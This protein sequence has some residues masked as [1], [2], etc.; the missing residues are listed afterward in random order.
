MGFEALVDLLP[1]WGPWLLG[2]AAF[3]S[4][5]ALPVPSTALLLAAGALSAS[6][7]L[8]LPPLAIAALAGAVLGDCSGYLLANRLRPWVMESHRGAALIG[9]AA[10][11]LER[12]GHVAL[13][14][15][16]W[17]FSPLGPFTNIAAGMSGLG[18]A[19]FLPATIAGEMVWIAIYLGIGRAFGSSYRAAADTAGTVLAILAGLVIV[20]LILRHLWR[21]RRA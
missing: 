5:L 6:D 3:L 16:R 10:A 19:R 20:G 17:L 9:R 14:L 21:R 12:R 1:Q 18:L 7:H 8:A 13:F 11:F 15:S 4:C 2:A